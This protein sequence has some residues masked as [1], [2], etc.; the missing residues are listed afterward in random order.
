MCL[1]VVC[2]EHLE[3]ANKERIKSLNFIL[4]YVLKRAKNINCCVTNLVDLSM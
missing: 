4:V 1:E 3:I 2:S